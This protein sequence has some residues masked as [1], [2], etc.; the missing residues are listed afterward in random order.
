MPERS[1]QEN[2]LGSKR[3][4]KSDAL[5]S[6]G[7]PGRRRRLVA[8]AGFAKAHVTSPARRECQISV[9]VPQ[10]P[11]TAFLVIRHFVQTC[12]PTRFAAFKSSVDRRCFRDFLAD[13]GTRYVL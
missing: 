2:D 7:P 12:S 5:G 13:S 6:G 10:N 9:S 4:Q 1:G 11:S 3:A 8:G